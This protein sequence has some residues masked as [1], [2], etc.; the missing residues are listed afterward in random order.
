MR[1]I[2]VQ[3]NISVRIVE[4]EVFTMASTGV[5]FPDEKV[6]SK[7]DLALTNGISDAYISACAKERTSVIVR[8]PHPKPAT[9]EEWYAWP[10]EM[11]NAAVELKG[12]FLAND[13]GKTQAIKL[14][15]KLIDQHLSSLERQ[16]NSIL[17]MGQNATQAILSDAVRA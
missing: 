6:F 2:L 13:A 7:D 3:K 9:T 8:V 4:G 15:K 14:I 17:A 11:I 10:D 16:K 1:L 12:I 5:T